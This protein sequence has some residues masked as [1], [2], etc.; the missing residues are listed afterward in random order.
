MVTSGWYASYWNAFLLSYVIIHLQK[1]M[2]TTGIRGLW[3]GNIFSFF[4]LSV[5][6]GGLRTPPDLLHGGGRARHSE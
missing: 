2:I 4:C 1:I 5:H 6:G 3:E